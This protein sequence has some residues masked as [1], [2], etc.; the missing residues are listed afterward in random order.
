[1]K[2]GQF[3]KSIIVK[4]KRPADAT[5]E[6]ARELRKLMSVDEIARGWG[7]SSA[8]VYAILKQK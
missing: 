2:K 8:R 4:G 1:M 6:K 7:I 3:E 5:P